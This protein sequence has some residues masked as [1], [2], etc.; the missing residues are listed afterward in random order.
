MPAIAI[1]AGREV[2]AG[3]PPFTMSSWLVDPTT[4]PASV[5]Q[6]AQL[7]GGRVGVHL[8]PR[9]SAAVAVADARAVLGRID[10]WAG[11]LT[12]F[13]AGSDLSRLNADPRGSVPIRPTLAAVLDW[14]RAAESMTDGI[15]NIALLDRRLAAE[16][17]PGVELQ[18][19]GHGVSA[20]GAWSLD[21]RPRG[22]LVRRPAGVRFDLDGV[23]KG[24][25]ADR[26]LA[27]LARYP[28]AVVDADGDVSILLAPGASWWIGVEDPGHPGMDVATLRLT[29]EPTAA[30]T[31][32]GIATSGTSVHRWRRGG[33]ASHHLID[34]RTGRPA[35]TDVVQATVIARSS[36]AAEA[37]AKAAVIL[38]SAAALDAL[39]RPDVDGLLILTEAGELLMLPATKNL[40][41]SHEKVALLVSVISW[42]PMLNL[43]SQFQTPIMPFS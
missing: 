1:G 42:P 14:G 21:R 38:G 36:R 26:A 7:M 9:D 40:S 29:G 15:V 30:Q 25:L 34:P 23:G 10:A 37:W 3:D 12:R 22:T 4:G 35:D 18:P 13:E 39:D 43:P 6:E 11:R 5:S 27:R 19:E 32:F 31:R 16:S 28:A 8:Q 2:A 24:W 17:A 41:R 33:V 20:A